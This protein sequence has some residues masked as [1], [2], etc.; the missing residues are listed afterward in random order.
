MKNNSGGIGFCGVLTIVFIVWKL[1]GVIKWSWLWVLSPLWIAMLIV[2]ILIILWFK[3]WKWGTPNDIRKVIW[4][5][6]QA[7][8]H[9]MPHL[10]QVHIQE[11]WCGCHRN[12]VKACK[13]IPSRLYMQGKRAEQ[14]I[15]LYGIADPWKNYHVGGAVSMIG[16]TAHAHARKVICGIIAR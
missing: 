13:P 14:N 16:I 8:Q 15:D 10:R 3:L 6:K 2:I 5:G 1:V 4:Q 12:K 11:R 9:T 7:G